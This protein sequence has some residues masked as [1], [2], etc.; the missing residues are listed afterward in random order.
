[1]SIEFSEAQV[2][3]IEHMHN[4]CV[5]CGN[6]GSGKSRTALGYYYMQN[7]GSKEFLLGGSY[8]PM[9]KIPKDLYIITT[10]K[11][12]DS[13]DWEEEIGP[14]LMSSNPESHFYENHPVVVD[15][16]N[17][18]QKYRTVRN[19]FFIFDEQRVVG[20]GAWV[21]A[22]LKIA[23]QNEWILLS[24]T[25]GDTWM[26]YVPVFIA[27]GFFKNRTEFIDNHVI[28]K[29][30]V[31][32]PAIDRYINI[33]RLIRLRKRIL[34]DLTVERH[35]KPH[36]LDIFTD[37]DQAAYKTIGKDR[38][39]IYENK[40]IRNAA[41]LCYVWRKL[42]N[43]DTS[44]QIALLQVLEE[45]DRVII[46]YNF[47]YE[48]DILKSILKPILPTA[49]WNGHKHQP[50]PETDTWAYLV[51]YN[52]GAEGWNCIKT[53]CIVF[54][55]QNYSYKIMEQARGRIDRMNT[56]YVDLYYYHLRSKSPIDRGIYSAL[57]NKKK[58]NERNFV[59]W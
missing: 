50:I 35:T 55:S 38:W 3:A 47:D 56:L 4:G 1:M 48:L 42:V 53:N 6:V 51:Q 16:W 54:Y 46:F 41:E 52:A 21:K 22:F 14:F 9:K 24:A 5:L 10:A 49:E 12:R 27:N 15:S 13:L 34:V 2:K 57:Q 25:P 28:Y 43:S 8:S 29:R 45:F 31:K 58:F 7:G 26:D 19:A 59:K 39:N 40:P 30:F 20:S 36:H 23:K 44:R 11:K 18:I 32:Y 17:N 33:D 37:Y